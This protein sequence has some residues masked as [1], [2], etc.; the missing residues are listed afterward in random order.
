MF[1]GTLEEDRYAKSYWL[2]SPG[3][4]AVPGGY[5]YFGPGAVNGGG[6]GRGRVSFGSAGV[7]FEVW[8]GVRPVVYLKSNILLKDVTISSSGSE[9]EWTETAGGDSG[10]PLEYGQIPE[11]TGEPQ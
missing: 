3:V 9:A 5:C 2:A 6:V 1:D 11:G 4:L 7:F 8:F 10:N